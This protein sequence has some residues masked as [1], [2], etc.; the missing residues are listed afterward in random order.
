[1]NHVNQL[2]WIGWSAALATV[3]V[4][5][6]LWRIACVR[7]GL[8]DSP[9]SRKVHEKPIPLA[10][11]LA[12]LGG[13]LVSATLMLALSGEMR[14]LVR[15][16]LGMWIAI[17]GGAV[18]MTL[19]GV[20]DDRHELRAGVKFTLQLAVALG[21]AAA[22]LRITLF[23]PNLVFQYGITALWI[24]TVINALN[25]MDNMNGLCAGLGAIASATFAAAASRHD[26]HAE[27]CFSLLVC[28][29]L[30]GFLPYNFP[31]AQAFL[32]DAGSHLIGFCMAVLAI[33]P[34]FHT[35]RDTHPLAVLKPLLI[36]AVPLLDMAWVV[37]LRW[38]A[39]TPFYLGD[40]NHLSHRLVRRN[41]SPPV[42]VALIWLL[43]AVC[44]ALA[45]L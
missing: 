41:L 30:L 11:G 28:G 24:L 32:G 12:V 34:S 15:D 39:G 16:R 35:A 37:V 1:M 20:L 18:F 22:G 14:E 9:G 45:L 4:T 26:Q 10:G 17:A 23:V 33:L 8:L 42:A 2:N 40:T 27:V 43:A 19:V 3:L 6:P 38:R 31:R 25:F 7:I 5:L 13:L 36:L 21:V 29:A 44:G